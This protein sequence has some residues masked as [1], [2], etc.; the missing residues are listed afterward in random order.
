MTSSSFPISVMCPSNYKDFACV[1]LIGIVTEIHLVR[2][3]PS[4]TAGPFPLYLP[5]IVVSRLI[6][7]FISA[8]CGSHCDQL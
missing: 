1:F 5:I 3:I 6:I 4:P 2:V 7:V 8:F